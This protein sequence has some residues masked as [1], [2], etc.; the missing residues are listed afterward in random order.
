M[1]IVCGDV[2]AAT[3][4]SPVRS[5]ARTP[6]FTGGP[7]SS[8]LP[9]ASGV[10]TAVVFQWW[11]PLLLK[12]LNLFPTRRPLC[13]TGGPPGNQGPIPVRRASPELQNLWQQQS[14]I[15]QQVAAYDLGW[16]RNEARLAETI[17]EPGTRHA[18]PPADTSPY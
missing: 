15:F 17:P 6:G 7:R 12:P 10:N 18:C 2:L 4:A 14:N 8:L 11:M 5:L 13:A 9:P 1:G 16:S 3:C